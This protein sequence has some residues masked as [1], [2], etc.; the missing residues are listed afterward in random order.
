MAVELA[1]VAIAA[2]QD[3]QHGMPR[4]AFSAHSTFGF[5]FQRCSRG[6]DFL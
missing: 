4:R 2:G 1:D 6:K 5:D 3:T